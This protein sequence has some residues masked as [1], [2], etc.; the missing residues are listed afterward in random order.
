M[1]LRQ[2]GIQSGR[3]PITHTGCTAGSSHRD[4]CQSPHRLYLVEWSQLHS[5][6]PFSGWHLTLLQCG[7]TVGDCVAGYSCAN[8]S[9]STSG[10]P[11]QA[12]SFSLAGNGS[13]LD[14]AAPAG[15]S[16]GITCTTPTGSACPEGQWGAGGTSSCQLCTF[17][18]K[19]NTCELKQKPHTH[20][21]L[22]VHP[23]F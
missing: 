16:C 13:C 10:S 8:N 12:G 6:S 20:S 23:P 1:A 11:C 19:D 15:S 22:L 21:T 18:L 14:C 5:T 2:R 7:D 17:E 4:V 3:S 9:L